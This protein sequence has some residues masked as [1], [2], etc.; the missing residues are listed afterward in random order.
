MTLCYLNGAMTPLADA[1]IG[2]SDLTLLRGYGVFD[3]FLFN[4]FKPRFLEDYLDRFYNSAGMLHLESPNSKH[5]LAEAILELITLNKLESGGIRLVLT[6]G[7]S[8]DAYTPSKGNL[9]VL[10]S[11]LPHVSEDLY[12][13]GARVA[14]YQH[15]RVIPEAKSLDYTT[16]IYLLPWLKQRQAHYPLYHDGTYVRESDRSN[17]FIVSN[18]G[19]LITSQKHILGGI[20]RLKILQLAKELQLPIEIREVSI[21]ELFSAD[22]VFFTS[23]IKGVLPVTNIDGREIGTGQPGPITRQLMKAFRD[24]VT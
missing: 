14:L 12:K 21:T 2:V 3:Y 23:S 5:Q 9:I 1:R 15:Q 24:L 6:G 10:Q 18:E 20:T 19:S 4:N 22:E 17:F 11:P 7:Y 8:E 16:G 13:N